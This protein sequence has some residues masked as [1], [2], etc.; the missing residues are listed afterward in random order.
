MN[1]TPVGVFLLNKQQ[2]HGEEEVYV[3]V[4]GLWNMGSTAVTCMAPA[5][6][7]SKR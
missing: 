2:A 6:S 4:A 3:M 5:L 7:P 1:Q